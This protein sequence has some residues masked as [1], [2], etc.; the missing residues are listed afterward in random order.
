MARKNKLDDTTEEDIPSVVALH[1][2]MNEKTWAKILEWEAVLDPQQ[3]LNSQTPKLSRFLGRPSDLS[4]KARFK[5]VL[6]TH[7]LP[8][9]RHDWTI[10]RPD[11]T[12]V[13]YVIDY[14]HDETRASEQ[15]NSGMPNM[16]D[17]EAVQSILVDVR[18]ALDSI[19][20]FKGRFFTMPLARKL[21]ETSFAPLPVFPTQEMK[22]QVKESIQVW[23]NI[24][25]QA[26]LNAKPVAKDMTL[27]AEDLKDKDYE[28]EEKEAAGKFQTQMDQMTSEKATQLAKSFADV[29]KQCSQAKQKMESCDKE[30]EYAQASLT[31]SMCM[32]QIVCPLQH[33]TVVKT[34]HSEEEH[35]DA[36]V[37]TALENMLSCVG[38]ENERVAMARMKFPLLFSEDNGSQ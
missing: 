7:P 10:V 26:K 27:K 32:A 22:G 24:Q 5:N 29:L 8:F 38:M 12:E 15:P 34:L 17:R 14:Y 25:K 35:Q 36:K 13:R 2:N 19:S 21:G 37:D 18:P 31:L 9:D 33:S 30:E 20:E 1:N 16:G 23:D 11:G 6:L 3:P 4:P 28:D